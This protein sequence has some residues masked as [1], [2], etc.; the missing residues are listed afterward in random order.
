MLLST[1]VEG[2]AKECGEGFL[3]N[4][5]EREAVFTLVEL[6]WSY[7]RTNETKT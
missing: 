2:V 7:S 6:V 5:G 3:E 4:T 1:R